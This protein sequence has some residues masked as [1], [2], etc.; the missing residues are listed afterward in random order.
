MAFNP[1]EKRR[2]LLS[3]VEGGQAGAS[4]GRDKRK[5]LARVSVFTL[6]IFA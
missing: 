6:T 3:R 2:S 5:P 4:V 1:R